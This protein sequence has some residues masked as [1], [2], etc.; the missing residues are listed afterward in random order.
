MINPFARSRWSQK[1][2]CT[3]VCAVSGEVKTKQQPTT[4][5][6]LRSKCLVFSVDSDEDVIEKVKIVCDLFS[7]VTQPY[8]SK[9]GTAHF[10]GC[11]HHG[12]SFWTILDGTMDFALLPEYFGGSFDMEYAKKLV[13]EAFEEDTGLKDQVG[14]PGKTETK[15]DQRKSG[16]AEEKSGR[17]RVKNTN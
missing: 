16:K 6:L 1:K 3:E 10:V 14:K 7:K 2:F 17:K 15:D 5:H 9:T 12:G 4:G 13:V 8:V 11:L